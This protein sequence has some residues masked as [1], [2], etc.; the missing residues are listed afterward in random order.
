M[1][2]LKNLPEL[3]AKYSSSEVSAGSSSPGM[4]AWCP[5]SEVLPVCL[6]SEVSVKFLNQKSLLGA[7]R[8]KCLLGSF[9]KKECAGKNYKVEQ[10]TENNHSALSPSNESMHIKGYWQENC[11]QNPNHWDSRI[12]AVVED[13]RKR[14]ETGGRFVGRKMNVLALS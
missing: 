4:P 10:G 8:Q 6:S 14:E 2:L 13:K 1:C 11:N 12:C 3:S 5:S 9:L 7:L